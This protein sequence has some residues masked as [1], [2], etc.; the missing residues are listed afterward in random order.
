MTLLDVV[1]VILVVAATVRGLQAG[2]ARQLFSLGCVL[3]GLLLGAWISPWT[4]GFVQSDRA[5]MIVTLLTIFGVATAIGAVGE[6]ARAASGRRA[7]PHPPRRARRHPRRRLRGD[8]HARSSSGCV[9]RDAGVGTDRQPRP[10]HPGV[11]CHPG[12]RRPAASEPAGDRPHRPVPRP[13]RVPARLRRPRTRPRPTR[14]PA[15]AP[16]PSRRRSD[17]TSPSTLKVEAD[18]VRRPAHGLRL[19][20]R[21]RLRRDERPRDRRYA[22]HRRDRPRRAPIGPSR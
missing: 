17:A 3:L 15:R 9:V 1:L 14:R 11:A 6:A 4:S 8:G 7:A 21:A 10:V 22:R 2:F 18:R 16:M 19:R 13:A 20:R 12:H 5:K